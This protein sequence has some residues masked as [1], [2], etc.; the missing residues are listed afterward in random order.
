MTTVSPYL[1]A[2][3]IHCVRNI[4]HLHLNLSPGGNFFF[5]VNGAGKTS[6]LEAV[7]FLSTG[8]S[9]RSGASRSLITHDHPVCRVVGRI[10]DEHVQVPMGIERHR[11]DGLRARVGGSPVSS[12]TELA[13]R[14][15]VVTIDTESLTLVTGTPE[16]RRRFLDATVFHVEHQFISLWRRYQRALRQRN[17]GLRRGTLAGDGAW[18]AEL[19]VAGEALSDIRD[20]VLRRLADTVARTMVELSPGLGDVS[21]SLRR[22]WESNVPLGEAIKEM[23]DS[24]RRQ[25]FTQRGPHRADVRVLVAGRPA[26][27]VLSRGQLKVLVSALRL[28]Q[29]RLVAA[30]NASQPL[31]LIDDLLAE[32]DA[33]HA[34]RICELLAESQSQVLMTAVDAG[35]LLRWWGTKPHRV[36]HVEHG[37]ISTGGQLE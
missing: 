8:R 11:I 26:A 24:D 5:G 4:E 31:Y 7:H 29:G 2:L 27:E 18:Q 20:N 15:P 33:N 30:A 37:N 13:E 28:A 34:E 22:G 16:A 32:L 6:V 12:L 9:F 21:L 14:L 25:G 3:Q 17:A 23:T 1:Q 36:F 10:G 19:A 35:N